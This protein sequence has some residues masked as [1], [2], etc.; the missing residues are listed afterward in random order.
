M[1]L[2]VKVQFTFSKSQ[3]SRLW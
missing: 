1:K 2:L 3:R